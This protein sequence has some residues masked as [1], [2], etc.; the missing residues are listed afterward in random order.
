MPSLVVVSLCCRPC[1]RARQERAPG[2]DQLRQHRPRWCSSRGSPGKRARATRGPPARP[3]PR[4]HASRP[5]LPDEHA[6]PEETATPRKSSAMTAVSAMISS[7]ARS[8]WCWASAEPPRRR[9]QNGGGETA[10]RRDFSLKR[11]RATATA[12]APSSPSAAWNAAA[13]PQIAA[14]FSV[15]PRR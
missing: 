5:T 10:L 12:S 13:I 3:S 14:T 15:P 8:S 9:F 7:D 4:A 2:F 11:S 6:A 1:R